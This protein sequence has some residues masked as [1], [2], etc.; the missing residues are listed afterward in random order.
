MHA[1]LWRSSSTISSARLPLASSP[2]LP[3]TRSPYERQRL[4]RVQDNMEY[5]LRNG[6]GLSKTELSGLKRM[7]AERTLRG[8]IEAER[9]L[10]G[11]GDLPAAGV[12][13]PPHDFQIE[14]LD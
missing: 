14:D 7:R 11:G 6:P 2:P 12:Y 8:M 3:L 1:T 10:P 13:V 4:S 9:T 5:R